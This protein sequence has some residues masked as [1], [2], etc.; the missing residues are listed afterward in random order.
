MTVTHPTQPTRRS[1]RRARAVVAVSGLVACGAL[2]AGCVTVAPPSP[3]DDVPAV[4]AWA[5]PRPA[6]VVSGALDVS[7]R[8]GSTL[9][10]QPAGQSLPA[11]V[12][13]PPA[14][15]D[16][17]V[18]VLVPS[19]ASTSGTLR[20]WQ[21]GPGGWSSALGPVRVR[22]GADGIGA[23]SESVD[24]TPR[25]TFGL[26]QAFGRR[27][28]PGTAL[29]YRTVGT[30]DWWVSDATSPAYNTYRHC[31]PGSCPFRE[32]AG[33]NLGQAGASYDYALVIGYNT[34]P[35]RKGAGSAF[36]V[37]VDAGARSQGCV[38]VPR[39]SEVALLRWL[40]PAR[41]PR[42]TIGLG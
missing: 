6:P 9:V 28:N 4:D 29:P 5:P 23:A 15:T 16:Q 38:E 11:G 14:G 36:F 10:E 24:R 39:A 40:V 25:G 3:P 12:P 18:T 27:P 42:I 7:A 35:V 30:S 26:D 17:L 21:R 37:H 33:E 19:A 8:P 34:S 1:Y 20:A 41:H 32:G 22:V 31:A 2:L 13:E